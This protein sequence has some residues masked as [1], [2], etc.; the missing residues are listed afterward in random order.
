M[1]SKNV[2][3]MIITMLNKNIKT[4]INQARDKSSK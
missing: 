1:L 3:T 4:I 2:E